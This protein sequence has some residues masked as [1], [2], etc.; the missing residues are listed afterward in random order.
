MEETEMIYK[1]IQAMKEI[2]EEK[3]TEN[4]LSA[5]ISYPLSWRKNIQPS[6]GNRTALCFSFS[7][8]N[9]GWPYLSA[10]I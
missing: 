10:S 8:G 9:T 1:K 6:S 7:R 5:I 3:S 2:S 4:I